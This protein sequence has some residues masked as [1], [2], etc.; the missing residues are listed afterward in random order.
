MI[1]GFPV[2]KTGFRCVHIFI[3]LSLQVSC[4]HYRESCYYCR[5]PVFV[6]GNGFALYE[7]HEDHKVQKVLKVHKYI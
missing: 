5:D 2:M 4:Y 1:T 7:I 3:L 6:T